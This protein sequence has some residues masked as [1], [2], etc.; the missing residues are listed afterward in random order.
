MLFLRLGLSAEISCIS[1][2]KI[3]LS[4]TASNC[5]K[6]SLIAGI[7]LFLIRI[8]YQGYPAMK[9]NCPQQE[10]HPR[11]RQTVER[12][13]D[14]IH[15]LQVPSQRLYVEIIDDHRAEC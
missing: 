12:C 4:I 1:A 11:T 7:V 3:F 8:Q 10:C 13:R 6:A 14:R 2:D 15:F 5:P 9:R